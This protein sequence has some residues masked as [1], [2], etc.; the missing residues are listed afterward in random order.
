LGKIILAVLS[1][2]NIWVRRVSLSYP[3]RGFA[4]EWVAEVG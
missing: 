4:N 3:A 2:M 1:K